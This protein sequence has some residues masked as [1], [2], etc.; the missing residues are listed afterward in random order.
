MPFLLLAQKKG[1]KKRAPAM[2]YSHCRDS[3]LSFCATVNSA[4]YLYRAPRLEN[5]RIFS[6]ASSRPI[7]RNFQ[8]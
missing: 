6:T 4:L 3:L 1:P 7:V 5:W 8:T 2:M